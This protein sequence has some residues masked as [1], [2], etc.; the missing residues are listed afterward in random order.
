[1]RGVMGP[2]AGVTLKQITDGTSKTIMI[3]EIRAGLNELDTRGT[4]AM[5]LVGASLLAKY[6]AESDSNGPNACSGHS[7]DIVAD[8][9][10]CDTGGGT[11]QCI[12]PTNS[13]GLAECMTCHR[14]DL[15]MQAGVRSKH[16]GGAHLAMCDGSVQYVSDDV[17]TSG[18]YGG[19]CAV[20]D[21]M[22]TS[23]GGDRG[24]EYQG[25]TQPC[26]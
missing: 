20:W 26:L 13:P 2:D 12:A 10:L 9:T 18:C 21:H 1:M 16:P 4:W 5:G 15:A 25:V 22:I 6:G 24:G 14:G 8:P 7:D 3:G 19:C 23:A 11:D 17:E